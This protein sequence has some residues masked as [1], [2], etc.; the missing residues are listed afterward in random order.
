MTMRIIVYCTIDE[1]WTAN[2][3]LDELNQPGDCHD[4][5]YGPRR[6]TGGTSLLERSRV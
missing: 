1:N 4:S 3:M 5:G 2:M 6:S